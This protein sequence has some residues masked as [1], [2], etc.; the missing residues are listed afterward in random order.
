MAASENH[1]DTA[2]SETPSGGAVDADAVDAQV[3]ERRGGGR[4]RRTARSNRALITD[5]KH[6]P[7]QNRQSRERQYAILQGLRLPFMLASIAAAFYNWWVLAAVLFVVSVP[8]PWIAVVMGNAVGEPR[9]TRTK[10]VYK[11]A[12]AREYERLEAQR[13]MQ[14]ESGADSVDS[15]DS[16]ANTPAIIDHDERTDPGAK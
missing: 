6:S 11:P 5:A 4:G 15:A 16:A 10:N 13:R 9:D 3:S 2:S 14:L 1:T 12:A 7:E 8:L